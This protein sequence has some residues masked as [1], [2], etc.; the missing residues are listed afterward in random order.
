M[1][2]RNDLLAIIAVIDVAIYGRDEPVRST[3]IGERHN[4]SFRYFEPTLHLLVRRGVLQGRRGRSGGYQLAC[5]PRLITLA[6]IIR[7]VRDAE[8]EVVSRRARKK[9]AKQSAI[10][11]VVLRT[12]EAALTALSKTGLNVTIHDLAQSAESLN[13]R[14]TNGRGR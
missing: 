8:R 4:S 14:G 6:D 5:D 2:S 7:T 3:D 10:E 13:D 9:I 12:L 11:Q 1:V